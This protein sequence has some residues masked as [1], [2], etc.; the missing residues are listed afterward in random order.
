M[1]CDKKIIQAGRS[2]G[3]TNV[4]LVIE[5]WLTAFKKYGHML[6]V[7]E[8]PSRKEFQPFK[9]QFRFILDSKRKKIYTWP[10][11]G[12]I[13]S[14]AW[15]HIKKELNDSRPL[16]KTGSLLPGV[17]ESDRVLFY[18]AELNS[19][20]IQ[21]FKDTDWSFAKRWVDMDKLKDALDKL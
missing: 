4:E 6:E 7:Y 20:T 14:D 11:T 13:H 3:K 21:E 5:K 9:D 19:K 16:Y 18:E 12:A 15:I 8:N 17:I 2:P 1:T 10:A